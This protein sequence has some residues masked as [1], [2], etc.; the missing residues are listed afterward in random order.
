MSI[1]FIENKSA[2]ICMH[3]SWMETSS[4]L[5]WHV[6]CSWVKVIMISPVVSLNSVKS[7]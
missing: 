3:F 4:D 6:F 5:T 2:A 1:S 7:Y